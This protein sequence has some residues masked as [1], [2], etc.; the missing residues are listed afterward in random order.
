MINK[1]VVNLPLCL[2]IYEITTLP[3]S[4]LNNWC[5]MGCWFSCVCGVGTFFFFSFTSRNRREVY[6]CL[7]GSLGSFSPYL[8]VLNFI[9]LPF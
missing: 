7:V 6:V 8:I 4:R 9:E 3:F 2:W 1:L 5:K